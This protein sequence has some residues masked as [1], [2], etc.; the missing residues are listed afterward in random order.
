MTGIKLNFEA[1][2]PIFE[3]APDVLA[4]IAECKSVYASA[5]MDYLK[6]KAFG[7]I[8]VHSKWVAANTLKTESI[9]AFF[10]NQYLY[11][12]RTR[13][14]DSKVFRFYAPTQLRFVDAVAI[15]EKHQ[16]M[17]TLDTHDHY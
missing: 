16:Q 15:V 12:V 13:D 2:E 3:F 6:A 4:D 10:D 8:H 1:F 17:S 9:A 14:A 5:Y 11:V 7:E